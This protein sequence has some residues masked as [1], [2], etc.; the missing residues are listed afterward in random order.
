MLWTFLRPFAPWLIGAALVAYPLT[1]FA[2]Y[3]AGVRSEKAAEAKRLDEARKKVA[4]REVKAEKITNAAAGELERTQVEIRWRTRTLIKEVPTYVTPADDALCRIPVG[5]VQLHDAAA[6]G[7]P[8][9]SGGP[10][11]TP[12]GVPLSS[13]ASTVADN[14]GTAHALRAEVETWRKWYAEQKAAWEE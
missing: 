8:E 7:L 3:Q 11:P 4:K 14:Y 9:P 1:Y 13:V 10:D 5:F 2:G 6:A 12:S